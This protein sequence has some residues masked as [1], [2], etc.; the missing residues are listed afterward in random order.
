[1][2]RLSK[3][4]GELQESVTLA[5]TAKAKKLRAEGRDV[6]SFGAGEPDFDTPE[7]IKRAGERAIKSGRT[8]YTPVGGIPELK[9]AVAAVYKKDYGIEY[10]PEEVLVSCGAKHSLYNLF[11]AVLDPG[12]EVIIPAPYWVSYPAMVKLAGGVPRIVKLSEKSGFRLSGELVKKELTPRTKALIINSP[13]NPTGAVVPKQNLQDLAE[14]AL[15]K[16][17]LIVSDEI[18]DK[19]VYDDTAV[20]SIASLSKDVKEKTVVV[21]GVSKTYSMTGWR[22]GY[23]LGPKDII[24]AMT[25]IQSQST[26]NPP[27]VSQWA[28][29]EALTGPQDEVQR[30]VGEFSKRRDVMV[31][32]LNAIEGVRCL[33][34]SGAFYVFPNVSACYGKS[35]NGRTIGGSVDLAEYL[36]EEAGVAVVPGGA[37]GEDECIRLSYATSMDEIKEGIKRIKEALE[38]LE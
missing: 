9:E 6:I 27:S 36:I 16:D 30:M 25:G 33:M 8:K 4:T 13:S 20:I 18:Y 1:M 28:A 34:P 29:L 35:F 38:R 17:I 26:S 22:I 11:Q 10:Q 21:N 2:T 31:E 3:R 15:E 23:A 5:I 19:I 12:D 14:I 37:F 32:G 7:N 24:K